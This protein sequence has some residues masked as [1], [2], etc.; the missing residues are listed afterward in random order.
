VRN[1]IEKLIGERQQAGH[2]SFWKTLVSRV[3]P[4]NEFELL[5]HEV[6]SSSVLLFAPNRT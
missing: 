3:I 2:E 5:E 1:Y 4:E 6:S